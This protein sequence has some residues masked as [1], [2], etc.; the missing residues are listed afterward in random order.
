MTKRNENNYNLKKLRKKM[1]E[2]LDRF[3]ELAPSRSII[4]RRVLT[5][6]QRVT[7]AM[8]RD[9]FRPEE[10]TRIAYIPVVLGR[11]VAEWTDQSVRLLAEKR[12]DR[13]KKAAR[14]A[15]QAVKEWRYWTDRGLSAAD[16]ANIDRLEEE[17]RQKAMRHVQ[18]MWWSIS[19]EAKRTVPGWE[20]TPWTT[21]HAAFHLYVFTCMIYRENARLMQKRAGI[22]YDNDFDIHFAGIGV[23]LL[24][25]TEET[26]FCTG[27]MSRMCID[28]LANVL[29]SMDMG[30]EAIL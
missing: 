14:L 7:E 4:Q 27:S 22:R 15:R 9:A 29:K 30:K 17:F 13:T 18:T 2:E 24:S 5:D 23:A 12:V 1:F 28:I 3:K 10:M 20:D 25:M 26:G 21:V 19:N 11:I 8:M 16:K 6:G